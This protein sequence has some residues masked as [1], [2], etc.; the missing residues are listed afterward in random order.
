MNAV[1]PFD[2]NVKKILILGKLARQENTGDHGSS[3][4]T[5]PY[6]I[7][8]LAGLKRNFDKGVKIFHL[9]ETQILKAKALASEVDCVIIIAGNDFSDEGEFISPGGMDDFIEPVVEGYKNM[10]KAIQA[11]LIKGL[12]KLRKGQL[13]ADAGGD[14]RNLSL[15]PKRST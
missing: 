10:G 6:V 4:V 14:R 7:T 3:R 12:K 2:K 5:P 15:N 1:L 11:A 8:T 13:E 9:D